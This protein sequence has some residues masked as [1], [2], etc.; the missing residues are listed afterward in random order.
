MDNNLSP[1]NLKQQSQKKNALMDDQLKMAKQ[2]QRA[3]IQEADF[4]VNGVR[5]TSRYMPALD[6]GG[7][8]YDMIKL[9]DDSVGVFISDVSGHGI[10]AA[11]LT[12]MIKMLFRNLVFSY[13]E[14]NRLLSRMNHEF[15]NIFANKVT[16]VYAAA[17]YAKID[18][19]ERKIYYSNAGQSLPLF[20]QSSIHTAEELDINGLPL[21][22]MENTSYDL[23]TAVFE[24]G[25]LILFYTDG[26]C[27]YLYKN[28]P[29]GF[30]QKLK[31][32]LLT[33]KNHP[34]EEIIE[35][36]LKHFYILDYP[37]VDPT[38]KYKK[39]D[40]SIIICKI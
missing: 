20:I 39:D 7:D 29:E 16:D 8:L 34:S 11:L 17:F 1:N 22:L 9:D 24:K 25:D 19:K 10:S 23:G 13:S 2:I 38:S 36:I 35:S 5:F 32:V 40:V 3:L 30:T 27:D 28:N 26:L 12:S 18:T 14:P 15:I 21:G 6:I 31:K 37:S 33:Y 4:S